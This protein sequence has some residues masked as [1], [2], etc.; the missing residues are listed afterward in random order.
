MP[1]APTRPI[2]AIPLG[3]EASVGD[4]QRYPGCRLTITC[5]MCGWTRGYNPE[6]ILRRLQELKVGGYATPLGV[7]ARRVQWPCPA[8]HRVRWRAGLG[9]P[10]E[11]TEAEAR[12]LAARA[13]N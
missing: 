8:C 5:A 4:F 13:R 3:P 9:W 6:R 7:V 12:R 2:R 10:P 1:L 11:L